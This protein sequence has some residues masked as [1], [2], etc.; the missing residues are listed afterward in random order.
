MGLIHNTKEYFAHKDEVV[1]SDL[2]KKF[3]SIEY[4]LICFGQL[5]APYLGGGSEHNIEARWILTDG[6]YR[7]FSV[8]QPDQIPQELCLMF[9]CY[10]EKKKHDFGHIISCPFDETAREFSTLLS[11]ATRRRVSLLSLRRVEGNP[12]NQPP[13]AFSGHYC[14][15]NL[16]VDRK[17]A[18]GLSRE[19]VVTV[20]PLKHY[21]PL[22][23]ITGSDFE[24]HLQ[25]LL[26]LDGSTADAI[27]LS[28]RLYHAA[29]EIMYQSTDVAYLLLVSAIE[30]AASVEF[31]KENKRPRFVKFI[32]KY[33]PESFWEEKDDFYVMSNEWNRYSKADLEGRLRDIYDRRSAMLHNGVA[34]PANIELGLRSEVHPEATAELFESRKRWFKIPS[35]PWF[36]RVVNSCLS[37]FLLC[38]EEK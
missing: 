17:A 30:T 11:L 9:D 35:I 36:E 13:Y 3:E 28:L 7:L 26:E 38:E 19:G 20:A 6:P 24:R 27:V 23:E 5:A 25:K 21:N 33:L 37:E 16:P 8:T 1:Q 10:Y 15:W 4:H 32:S 34:F 18:Y 14:T 22:K 29:L 12:V 31:K 2:D